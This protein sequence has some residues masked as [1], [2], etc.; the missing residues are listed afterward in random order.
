MC[1]TPG[2]ASRAAVRTLERADEM[3]ERVEDVREE[4]EDRVADPALL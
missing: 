3:E 2:S 1:T 4:R